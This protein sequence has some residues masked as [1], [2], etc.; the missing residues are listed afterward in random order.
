M[1]NKDQLKDDNWTDKQKT[2][3]AYKEFVQNYEK[4]GIDGYIIYIDGFVPEYPDENQ[5]SEAKEGNFIPK[6]KS[7]SI[8]ETFKKIKN[9]SFDQEGNYISDE[10]LDSKY[11]KDVDSKLE[12]ASETERVNAESKVKADAMPAFYT[13]GKIKVKLTENGE[14]VDYEGIFIKEGT[15]IGRT[16]T[17]KELLESDKF[18]NGRYGKYDEI[19][20]STNIR[21]ED[22][23]DHVIGNYLRVLM[24]NKVKDN[25]EN[26]EDYM[27]LDTGIG[28]DDNKKLQ[29]YQAWEGDL[30]ILATAIHHE[31]CNGAVKQRESN[32]EEAEYV[33]YCM[34]YSIVNKVIPANYEIYGKSY[35]N[36][37]STEWSPLYQVLTNKISTWYGGLTLDAVEAIHNGG[38]PPD[39]ETYC[40]D[41][42][43]KAEYCLTYDCTS[44]KKP[45]EYGPMDGGRTTISKGEEIPQLMVEQGQE[46]DGAQES[47]GWCIVG[48]YDLNQDR[49]YIEQSLVILVVHF[50][51]LIY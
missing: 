37:N 22:N 28:E 45:I 1:L 14:L 12:S 32:P 3:Y 23:P 31:C 43:E 33:G 5:D 19:R 35:Y 21:R 42:L 47:A 40:D 9:S 18:R 29:E 50:R 10:K 27:K 26:V 30:E 20:V 7:I 25:I 11:E 13:D 51:L 17:D 38:T 39:G 2:I 46:G 6:G 8:D 4:F 34:G 44:V 36:P 15:V 41:C 24:M 48:F 16:I 49:S